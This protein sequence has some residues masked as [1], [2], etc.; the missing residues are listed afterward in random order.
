MLLMVCWW[1]FNYT[2]Y[3]LSWRSALV[4][5]WG[6]LRGAVGMVMALFIFLDTQ[7]LDASFKSY[8]IFYM[9]T[10]AFFT[11]LIN[12]GSTK[13]RGGGG[14]LA[15]KQA[16]VVGRLQERACWPDQLAGKVAV[17]QFCDW[18][19]VCSMLSHLLLRLTVC[20]CCCCCQALL[21]WLGFL[22]YTPEQLGTLTHVIEDMEH[23]REQQLAGLAPDEVLGEPE[24]DAVKV[25]NHNPSCCV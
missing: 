18:E 16:R 23:I 15:G 24:P 22:S 4:M 9:G 13:V 2:G 5:V 19:I 6:G 8:C 3:P 10:M 25:V 1:P 17:H 7:I 21:K 14:L 20:C 11:V 12:G